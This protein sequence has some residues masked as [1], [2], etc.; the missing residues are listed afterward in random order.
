MASELQ[1]WA[2][3]NLAE[4]GIE[5][6]WL[7]GFSKSGLGAMDLLLKHPDLF[8]LAAAWDFPADMSSYTQYGADGNYG[9]D[10]NFQS[11][12][13]LTATFLDAHKT[14]FLTQDRIWIEGYAA[15]QLDVEDF[16]ALL[17]SKGMAHTTPPEVQRTHSWDS[18]W[19]SDALAGLHQESVALPPTGP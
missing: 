7:I 11:N 3:A 2:R 9:S 19:V 18:G 1:P 17:T 12:Y 8:T 4:T 10:A 16:D 6:H 5:Q 15:F 14:P 13:R